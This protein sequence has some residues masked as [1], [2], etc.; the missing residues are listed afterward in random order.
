[1]IT[2]LI[3][4]TK[5]LNKKVIVR[6][7]YN[8]IIADYNRQTSHSHTGTVDYSK[9][10]GANWEHFIQQHSKRWTMGIKLYI[11]LVR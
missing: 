9:F 11:C 4:L 6:N 7:P 1:M 5:L 8:A 2:I 3:E 10:E